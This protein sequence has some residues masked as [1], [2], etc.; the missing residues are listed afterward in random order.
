MSGTDG[1]EAA[2]LARCSRYAAQYITQLRSHVLYLEVLTRLEAIEGELFELDAEH[3]FYESLRADRRRTE[4]QT[5]ADLEAPK[6][7][8]S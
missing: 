6:S 2:V 8:D 7:P 5:D 1:R 3:A 4:A